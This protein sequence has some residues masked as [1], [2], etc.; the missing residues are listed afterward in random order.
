MS[1]LFIYFY[2]MEPL[3]EMFNEA[4]YRK[5]ANAFTQADANFDAEGF[6]NDV[7]KDIALLSLNAR[8]RNT[9]IVLHKYLPKEFEKTL[10]TLYD[11]STSLPHGYTALV[12]PDFVALN[13]QAYFD[14]SMQAL[15]DFTAMGS[16]EFAVRTFLKADPKR[17]LSVMQEWTQDPNAHVRR[18]ASEGS[19]P[20]LPWSFK[21]DAIIQEPSLTRSILEELKQDD[22]LYVRKSVA[23]HLN[24]HSKD[25]VEY[26]I[27]LLRAWDISHVH[28][29]WI[30]K[31]AGRSLIKKGAPAVL[32]IFGFGGPA[33]VELK[34]LHLK[35]D[36]LKLGEKLEFS[37]TLTS[38][39]E[40]KRKLVI[41]YAIH[42]V[43]STG[44][45]SK[46]VFK[47][48][49]I[50][51]LPE[52]SIVVIKSQLMKDFT[53]RKHYSGRHFLDIM[54]NGEVAGTTSFE[55]HTD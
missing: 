51:M 16:S 36:V 11:A 13:G 21:L 41:D 49:E 37:F 43:K 18:L 52:Q 2:N 53:T 5:F 4:F 25:N 39:E 50:E 42:Y 17:A 33:N 48:K 44:A 19:R 9:S 28:T 34:E 55:L 3:K 15:K 6:V 35:S 40:V 23:N 47:L 10:A 26:L 12:L 22:S 29:S 24:D 30:M 20:R 1:W 32:E 45:S 31:H 38:R 27:E 7:T 46:K 54:I 8:L 14:I